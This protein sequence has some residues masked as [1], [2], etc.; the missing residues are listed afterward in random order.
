MSSSLSKSVWLQWKRIE[1][2]E[3]ALRRAGLLDSESL[4]QSSQGLH[5]TVGV[6]ARPSSERSR[7]DVP[8]SATAQAEAERAGA[9]TPTGES[10]PPS[11]T[12]PEA[13]ELSSVS[14]SSGR[15]GERSERQSI[16]ARPSAPV[17]QGER[18]GSTR[19]EHG[20]SGGECSG[21]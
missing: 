21:E 11:C 18:G 8:E 15:R 19:T 9:T 12:R 1:A 5:S 13:E 4:G 20:T 2:I 14:G 16:A 17:I 7:S 10:S 6:V 3:S